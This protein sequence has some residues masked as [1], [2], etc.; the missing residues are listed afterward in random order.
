MH[1][2]DLRR[3]MGGFIHVRHNEEPRAFLAQV[4]LDGVLL[5]QPA[6]QIEPRLL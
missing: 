5:F 1:L 3:E 4:H 2:P 6:R